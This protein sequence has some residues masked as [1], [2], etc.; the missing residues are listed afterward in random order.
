MLCLQPEAGGQQRG[1][2]RRVLCA[3]CP[4]LGVSCVHVESRVVDKLILGDLA[5]QLNYNVNSFLSSR[6]CAY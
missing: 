5:G 2:E 4:G 1:V 3:G 6:Y